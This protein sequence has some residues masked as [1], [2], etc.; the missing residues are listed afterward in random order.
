MVS[1]S[2]GKGGQTLWGGDIASVPQPCFL[3]NFTSVDRAP[4]IPVLDTPEH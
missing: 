1:L 3:C 4:L 2:S